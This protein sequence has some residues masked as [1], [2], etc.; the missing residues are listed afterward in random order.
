MLYA[1][2]PDRALLTLTGPEASDFLQ[3][4]VTADVTAVT[5][6]SV[7]PAALLTPQGKVMFEFLLSRIDDGFRLDC[8][9]MTRA[10]LKKR[11][12]LYRLRRK[13][14]IAESEV[15]VFALWG[16]EAIDPVE[17]LTDRRFATG[18]VARVY[19]RAPS[20]LAEASAEAFRALRIS[21]GVAELLAD[22][23]PSEVFPHDVLMD[24][25]GAVSFKKG[26][27]VGQE[28]VSRMQ[29]RRT[30]RRRL[31]LVTGDAPLMAN[32]A[33]KAGDKSIGELVSVVDAAG[34]ALVRIDKLANA[35]A[36]G[37]AI[38]AEGEPIALAIPAYAGYVLPEPSDA[39]ADPAGDAA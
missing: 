19:G 1:A 32:T 28:V 24:F 15:P 5:A 16:E 27:Y 29:H 21:A 25:S 22:Y 39:A 3:G 10:E 7:A 38:T 17:A 8:P 34:L 12:T 20:G 30:A 13:I 35:A 31:M 33:V 4:L 14:E 2:L 18:A 37:E 11:L 26:C 6:D 23:P 9:A 36:R